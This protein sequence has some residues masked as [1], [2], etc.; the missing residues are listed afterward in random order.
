M[1]AST[2]LTSAVLAINAGSFFFA[3]V[4]GSYAAAALLSIWGIWYLS[5]GYALKIDANNHGLGS[6]FNT[7][8]RRLT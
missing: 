7:A 3:R 5:F 8:T 4:D 1:H 2:P 6:R